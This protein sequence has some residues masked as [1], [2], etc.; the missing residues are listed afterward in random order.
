[1]SF[2]IWA[3]VMAGSYLLRW[4]RITARDKGV[5]DCATFL[6]A[7]VM[8][9]DLSPANVALC[10]LITAAS[11]ALKPKLEA[12]LRPG[13]RVVMESFP[14]HGW[15]PVEIRGEYKVFYLYRMPPEPS[16]PEDEERLGA[17]YFN[18]G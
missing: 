8:D 13:T 6:E 2:M 12:E 17:E 18:Y 15:K 14:V 1:M 5:E 11:A 7:D 16:G 4:T 10:Y 9:V 3:P